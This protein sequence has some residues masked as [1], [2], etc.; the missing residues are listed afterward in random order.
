MR[1]SPKF[2][3]EYSKVVFVKRDYPPQAVE[4]CGKAWFTDLRKC[5]IDTPA[6]GNPLI[7]RFLQ[8]ILLSRCTYKMFQLEHL[9]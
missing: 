3:G 1:A 6:V 4:V 7:R 5:V 9:S 8:F 2:E